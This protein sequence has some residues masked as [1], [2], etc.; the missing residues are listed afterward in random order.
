MLDRNVPAYERSKPHVVQYLEM[1][2]FNFGFHFHLVE[3][4]DG[5]RGIL[6][7][8]KEERKQFENV[9]KVELAFTRHPGYNAHVVIISDFE[10]TSFPVGLPLFPCSSKQRHGKKIH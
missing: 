1:D 2:M 10:G 9:S 8:L 5:F 7:D 6:F 3:R 4:S